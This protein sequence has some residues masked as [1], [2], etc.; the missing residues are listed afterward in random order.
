[1]AIEHMVMPQ[2]SGK[3]EGD[4]Y[5]GDFPCAIVTTDTSSV[6]FSITVDF[7]SGCTNANGDFFAGLLIIQLSSDNFN[8]QV[9][10]YQRI[11]FTNLITTTD[12]VSG[13][14]LFTYTGLNGS[15]NPTMSLVSNLTTAG[16]GDE[17][18]FNGTNNLAIEFALDTV[19]GA[20]NTVQYFTGSG[21]GTVNGQSYTQTI[22]QALNYSEQCEDHFVSGELKVEIPAQADRFIDYGPG[23]CDDRAT[24]TQ[25]GVTTNITLQ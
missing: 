8:A 23:A 13:D 24:I 4:F 1:M 15:G 11:T 2:V 17:I 9:G 7:G 14:A 22:T 20:N 10:N 19:G 21:I 12:T 25:S 6:P 16:K 3:K 18:R 5:F